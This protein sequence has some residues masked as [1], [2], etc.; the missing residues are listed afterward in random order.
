MSRTSAAPAVAALAALSTL[1]GCGGDQD[2]RQADPFAA[3][4]KKPAPD[5][6]PAHAA[7][8]WE[9][10]ATW[11]G[12]GPATKRL[13][14]GK[15]AI[16]WR[17]RWRCRSGDFEIAVSPPP[18]D[19]RPIA[20][21][22]CPESGR[23][24]SIE[25]GELGVAVRASGAWRVVIEQQVD[26][27]LKEPPFAGM[28]RANLLVQG[29]FY[30]VDR[31]GSGT[32]SL[33]RLPSGRLGLRLDGFRTAPNIDLFVWL[34]EAHRPKTTAAAARAPH[35]VAAPLKATIGDQNFVLPARAS[36]ER[37]RSI[38]IW[39]EPVQN[40]YTAAALRRAG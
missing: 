31:P 4:E 9:H 18:L 25:S 32:A 35:V 27:P 11:T 22:E 21:S 8:R 38:V 29:R 16:Q 17:A 6:R 28:T 39:C 36:P 34:S 30:E 20:R 24:V 5:S 2:A 26:T 7:P 12:D 1:P 33:Y 10:L 14:I 3:I 37:I 15:R 19:R 23:G 40:V 13:T